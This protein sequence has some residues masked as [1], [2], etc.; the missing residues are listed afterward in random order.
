MID[1]YILSF[2]WDGKY[3]DIMNII[4]SSEKEIGNFDR[5]IDMKDNVEIAY[6]HYKNS[7]STLPFD[8]VYNRVKKFLYAFMS[9]HNMD[10]TWDREK[11]LWV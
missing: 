6:S 9:S 11:E 2:I 1:L 5:F 8:T 10:F 3:S 7:A 4:S